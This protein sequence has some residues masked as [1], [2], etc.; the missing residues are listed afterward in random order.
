MG[1]GI[2]FRFYI[3]SLERLKWQKKSCDTMILLFTLAI[4]LAFAEC[5]RELERLKGWWW[6]AGE[7]PSKHG[8]GQSEVAFKL[9]K[10]NKGLAKHRCLKMTMTWSL[11]CVYIMKRQLWKIFDEFCVPTFFRCC[12]DQL[13][14][15]HFARSWWFL[16][17]WLISSFSP[18]LPGVHCTA[19]DTFNLNKFKSSIKE[20]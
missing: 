8:V 7:R 1:I 18:T 19:F 12:K 13:Q 4:T 9:G 11:W 6:F 3:D 5:R 15:L 14:L 17:L 10:V 2:F 20:V 16:V